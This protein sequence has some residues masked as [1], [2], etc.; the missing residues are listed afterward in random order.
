MTQRSSCLPWI[1]AALIILGLFILGAV[2]PYVSG[3]LTELLAVLP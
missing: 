2:V 1:V 3:R